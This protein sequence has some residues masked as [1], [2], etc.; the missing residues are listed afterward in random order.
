VGQE[1]TAR[2]GQERTAASTD[3]QNSAAINKMK[4]VAPVVSRRRRAEATPK[5]RSSQPQASQ[6][7]TKDHRQLEQ[8][9]ARLCRARD[10]DQLSNRPER[11]PIEKT[12]AKYGPA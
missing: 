8:N 5:R 7:A 9:G 12:M 6:E 11:G 10:H 3:R 1:C 4:A 2:S